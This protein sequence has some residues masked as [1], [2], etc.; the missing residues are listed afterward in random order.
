VVLLL[1]LVLLSATVS[2]LA[3]PAGPAWAT[4]TAPSP[5]HPLV[6]PNDGQP[7]GTA[8]KAGYLPGSAGVSPTGAF[9]YQIP[10]TVPAGRNGMAPQLALTYAS[11]GG[12]GPFGLDWSLAGMSSSIT[13]CGRTP[14]T[15]GTRT[16]VHYDRFDRYCLDGQKLIALGAMEPGASGEYGDHLTV[17][18]TESDRFAQIV[19]LNDEGSAATMHTG[20]DRFEVRG[21]DGRIRGYQAQTAPRRQES[22]SLTRSLSEPVPGGECVEYWDWIEGEWVEEC[23]TKYYGTPQL[24]ARTETLPAPRVLWLLTSERDRSGNEIRY[25]YD[26]VGGT[27]AYEHRLTHIRYTYGPGRTAARSVD[28]EYEVRPDQSFSYLAGVRFQQTQRVK[29]ISMLAPN[30]AATQMVRRYHLSYLP[31][32]GDPGEH[33]RSLLWQVQECG[34]LGG[35]L[36]AKQFIWGPATTPQFTSTAVGTLFVDTVA[37]PGQAPKVHVQDLDGDGSDDIVFGR[38]GFGTGEYARLGQRDAAGAVTPLADYRQ[39]SGYGDWPQSGSG[40]VELANSRPLDIDGNGSTEFVVRTGHPGHDQVLRWDKATSRFVSAGPAMP[41]DTAWDDFGDI[42]GDGLIDRVIGVPLVETDDGGGQFANWNKLRVAVQRNTGGGSFGPPVV[43]TVDAKCPRRLSDVDGDG[44]ADLL[45]EPPFSWYSN[46]ILCGSGTNGWSLSESRTLSLINALSFDDTGWATIRS[47]LGADASGATD[48]GQRLPFLNPQREGRYQEQ[49]ISGNPAAHTHINGLY[50]WRSVLGDFNGDRLHDTLLVPTLRGTNGGWERPGAILWGTGSGLYWDGSTV[51][52]AHDPLADLRVGDLNGD[53]RDDVVSFY[54][55]SLTVGTGAD[56]EMDTQDDEVQNGPPNHDRIAVYLSNG[57]GGFVGSTMVTSAGSPQRNDPR[58]GRPFSQLGD[59]NGDGRLDIL[60]NDGTITVLTQAAAVPELITDVKNEGAGWPLQTVTYGTDWTDHPELMATVPACAAPLQCLRRGMQVVRLVY[61]REHAASVLD[62]G[63]HT[64]YEY[65]DPVAHLRQGFL[66][67]GTVRSWTPERPSEVI[68]TYDLRTSEAGGKYYPYGSLPDTV[69]TAVPIMTPDAVAQHPTTATA[70][71]TRVEYDYE[72]RPLNN[73]ATFVVYPDQSKTSTW[74]QQ[75]TLTWQNDLTGTPATVHV[76]GIPTAT[77]ANPARKVEQS[78]DHDNYGNLE[79]STTTTTGG[80]TEDATY[81]YDLTQPRIEEWLISLRTTTEVTR[82]EA[83]GDPAPVTRRTENGYDDLGRL[84]TAWVE[85][86][87]PDPD[88]RQT[89]TYGLDPTGVLRTTTVSAPNRPD[90]VSHTEYA[91]VFPGQPDELI[92]SSQQ[93]SEHDQVTDSG[94]DAVNYRPSTWQAVH[95][96]FGLAVAT[97]DINGVDSATYHDDLGRPIMTTGSQQPTVLTGYERHVNTQGDV[98]GLTVRTLT[99]TGP[100]GSNQWQVA[101]ATTDAAG[102]TRSSASSGFDGVVN[103]VDSSYD[104]FGRLVSQTRP[105]R[106]GAAPAGSTSNVHD[107]LD[108]PVTT[109]LP[110]QGMLSWA[111]VGLFV[112]HGFDVDDNMTATTT[113]VDGRKVDVTRYHDI[114]PPGG[115]PELVPISTSYDYAPFDKV[116]TATDDHGNVVTTSYDVRG[117]AVN[118]N[119]PDRGTVITEYDGAGQVCLIR[120]DETRNTTAFAVDDLGRVVSRTDHDGTTGQDTT[121]T[122]R[123]DTAT[124]GIGQLHH[125]TSPDAIRT[126]YRYDDYGRKIGTDVT[127]QTGGATYATDTSYDQFSRVTTVTY[128]EVPGN[129]RL[130]I[131]NGY[132]QYGYLATVTNTTAEQ[133]AATL[134]RTTARNA[135]LALTGAELGQPSG[136]PAP[137]TLARGYDGPTGRLTGMTATRAGGT[138][139]QSLTYGYH[140]NGLVETRTQADTSATRTETYGYDDLHRLTSWELVNGSSP[141]VTTGY[142]HDTIGNLTAI[143]GNP[144]QAESRG[145]GNLNGALPHALTS[146]KDETYG[147]DGQGRMTRT[148]RTQQGE[149]T[150][151][152]EVSYT[153]FDLPKTLTKRDSGTWTFRYDAFGGRVAKSG[154]DGTT[155]YASGLFERRTS[156]A[157]QHTYVHH[158]AGPDGPIGQITYTGAA[159]ATLTFTVSDALGSTGTTTDHAGQPTGSFFY[160]PYGSRVNPDG[161]A[162]APYTGAM[163]NGFTG[164]EHDD[165]LGKINMKGRI[166]SDAAKTFLTPDPVTSNHPYAYVNGNPTNAT[167]PTGYDPSFVPGYAGFDAFTGFTVTAPTVNFDYYYNNNLSIYYLNTAPMNMS[168][169]TGYATQEPHFKDM[170][171]DFYATPLH[172]FSA[173]ASIFWNTPQGTTNVPMI[174]WDPI[175]TLDEYETVAVTNGDLV[176][177]G[178]DVLMTVAPLAKALGAEARILAG[179]ASSVERFRIA[180]GP[181]YAWEHRFAYVDD[182]TTGKTHLFYESSGANSNRPGTWFPSNGLDVAANKVAKAGTYQQQVEYSI[183]RWEKNEAAIAELRKQIR[184]GGPELEPAFRWMNS[185]ERVIGE[186]IPLSPQ[187]VNA[188]GFGLQAQLKAPNPFNEIFISPVPQA[189][190][191]GV[192]PVEVLRNLT[193]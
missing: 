44:R 145:V 180:A 125:A 152:E 77:P 45:I 193:K 107:S 76:G 162:A 190:G 34:A 108:R 94:H 31:I 116:R 181:Y 17:Y 119:D 158:I 50:G 13:R 112:T 84:E 90:Q 118:V 40:G 153:P 52:L 172:A 63:V 91:P 176:M 65:S 85:R 37:P 175:P 151:T 154:P 32:G 101:T 121:T 93:W 74:E 143:T 124:N 167:D 12:D 51:D 78:F 166:Y 100:P 79:H 46:N 174:P 132:N 186:A 82:S 168:D 134:W 29:T 67:F 87:N 183:A 1:P 39:V 188:V 57:T 43:S 135:D 150:V 184:E 20:P 142:V 88:V 129:G 159:G 149:T 27:A 155:F 148:S 2:V 41:V 4:D 106:Y 38:G 146:R 71:V 69:T 182:L 81:G 5:K 97:E 163:H 80:V 83:D 113:D 59:F 170:V 130:A 92:Y 3:T 165:A 15:D 137:I 24:A 9:T 72:F 66:G 75:A 111:Y 96:A 120:H 122:F 102:H 115:P 55:A 147:Y 86:N 22:V 54:N 114:A 8:N 25:E 171:D 104:A 61:S 178:A 26:W 187:E 35:C 105:Y 127:D 73:D 136:G 138:T 18:H 16:G 89:T 64:Y 140:P 62:P 139:L 56:G 23:E 160:E 68:T 36:L 14:D 48:P 49:I 33:R 133:P 179:G 144:G 98:A 58:A 161:T 189:P 192:D 177:A 42:D 47:G 141:V 7:F 11:G 95:P 28:F 156:P 10:L 30:P 117:R 21:K 128:P 157:G 99:A 6:I 53:G 169:T 109:V 164:H 191:W 110:D 123:Y 185:G 131:T 60:K 70:R 19:S 126:A 173:A 103:I